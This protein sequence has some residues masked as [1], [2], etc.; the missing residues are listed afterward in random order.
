M[1]FIA[2]LIAWA[3]VQFW[4]SGGVIQQDEWYR[5]FRGWLGALSSP[6]LRLG[7][8]IVLPA[9]LLALILQLFHG[10]VFGLPELLISVVILLYS[11]GRGDFQ[12]QLRLYLNSWLR[13]D[14]EGAYRHGQ[15]FSAEL[16][17]SGADNVLELHNSVRR[18]VLYQGFERW[19]AVVFWFFL[20]GPVAALVYRLLFILAK[21]SQTAQAERDQAN[22]LLFYLEWLPVRLLGLAFG[23]VGY[24]EGCFASLRHQGNNTAPAIEL[25]DELAKGALPSYVQE[26]QVDGEQ[27]VKSAAE[28]LSAIQHLLSRSLVCWISVI[29]IAQLF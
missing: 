29:A 19:F 28:E 25:L 21:D 14:L 6:S 3:A 10:V 2:I 23:L 1:E 27:F 18:A 13:G 26:G 24:F 9:A 11:L 7:L 4:G 5:Q 16:C 15:S 8:A 22:T 17:E 20:L 12:I